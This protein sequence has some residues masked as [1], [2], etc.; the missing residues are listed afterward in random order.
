MRVTSMSTLYREVP[1]E[2]LEIPSCSFHPRVEGWSVRRAALNTASFLRHQGW[3]RADNDIIEIKHCRFFS[4]F[5]NCKN[6]TVGSPANKVN[7]YY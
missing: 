3:F 5:A 6:W 1:S 7:T 2:D 4:V